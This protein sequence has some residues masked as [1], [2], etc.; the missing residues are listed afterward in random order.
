MCDFPSWIEVGKKAVFATDDILPKDCNPADYV[1]HAGIRKLFP[2]TKG[3]D[4]EGYP[5]HSQ[6]AKAIMAGKMRQLMES[7]GYAS[8]S[9]NAKGQRHRLDGPAY[10]GAD[11]TKAWWVKDQ[12]HRLDGPAIEWADGTKEWWVKGQRVSEAECAAARKEGDGHV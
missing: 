6:V 10:E 2:E 5:C 12:L 1:G 7:A 8:V 11:G 9:V 3:V 4:R